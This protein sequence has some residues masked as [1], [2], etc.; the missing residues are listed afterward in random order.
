M[1]TSHAVGDERRRTHLRQLEDLSA[2]LQD[3]LDSLDSSESQRRARIESILSTLE[4]RLYLYE[5]GPTGNGPA[6]IVIAN[7]TGCSSVYASTMP[8][9]SYLD[10][11]VNSL[12]QDSSPLAKGI[13][14]GISAQ[15]V[16]D[17]RAMRLAEL[18]LADAYDPADHELELRMLSWE[19]FTPEELHLLPTVM[20]I[21]GDGATYDIGFGALSRVLA[22]D[23][24]IKALVLNSG[25]Y[26]NTGGQAST[27]SYT[28]QDSDLARFGGAHHG[29]HESRKELGLLASFHPNVFACATSTAMHAHFMAATMQ[30]LDYPA[31][32]VMDVYTPCGSEHGIPE[33]SSNARARLAVESRMHPLF[34]HD[35]RRGSTLHDWFSLDGNPDIDKT[36]TNSTLEYV[37]ESGQ[38]Q[39][40]TTALTPAVFA[41]GEV[42]FS[43]QFS[44]LTP[45]QEETAVPIEEYVEMSAAQ[46]G[47]RIPFIHATDGERRLIKVACSDSIVHLVED[48]RRYWQTL[49]YLSGV[50]EAQLTALHRSDFEE[51]KAKYEQATSAR[52]ASLDDIARAMSDLATSSRAPSGAGMAGGLAGGFGGGGASQ[53]ACPGGRSGRR[54]HDRSG[55][56][57]PGR[58]APV[59]RL[60]HLLPGAPAVLREGH[61]G[62]RRRD[63]A[64]RPDDPRGGRA[65]RGHAGDR[66]AD[67][68]GEG[69]VRRGD[70]PMSTEQPAGADDLHR[71]VEAST[72]LEDSRA[73]VEVLE[74][75]ESVETFTHQMDLLK[76]RLL[77]DPRAFRELFISEGMQA[78]AWE[79][80]Q[81]ELGPEFTRTLW[82]M[83]LREDDAGTVLMRFL[84][85]LPLGKK[86]MFIRAIDA[87]LSDRYPMFDGLSR[88][89]PAGNSIPPYVRGPEDRAHDFGLVNQGY[90]GYMNLGYTARDIDLL[91]WLEAMRDKQCSDKPC[92][93]GI[94]L[95]DCKEPTGGC[96]VQ[97]HI[98]EMIELVGN[99]R[100]RE[101]LQLIE[102]CNPLPDVT[103]RVCPQELQCQGVCV[104]NKLPIAIGQLEWF[105]PQREK[106]VN[107]GGAAA[108]LSGRPDPWRSAT[109]P[110]VAIVGSGPSGL[111]NAYLLASEGFPVTV[112]EAFHALGGVLRYGIPEFRLPNEL[113]DDVV[114]KIRLLGGRFVQ[115]FVVGKTATIQDLQGRRVPPDLRGHGCG[116]AAV[117]ERPRRAPAQRDER[118][119]VPDP[120]EPDAGPARGLRDPAARDQGQ[121]GAGHRRRQHRDGRRP[122]SPAPRWQRHH[123]LPPHPLGDARTR[124]GAAPCPRGGHRPARAVRAVGVPRR[125]Q[126]RLRHRRHAGDHGAR[127]ARRVRA[128]A[129]HLHGPHRDHARRPGDHGPGQRRQPDHQG[130][131][132]PAQHVQVGNDRPGPRRL[133]G[134][135]ARGRLHRRR[136]RARRIDGHRRSRRRPGRGQ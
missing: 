31:A 102:S 80:Q 46:R 54:R 116:T 47:D 41:L 87:H 89:W 38:V 15:T 62:H 52:E 60:R 34:V 70:H 117:H 96:P 84:W 33:A 92:E 105:L 56:P 8:Y 121:G 129:P 98:P 109:K 66:Q 101:A 88:D 30:L 133:A 51:L 93:L 44:R 94:F 48:R 6:P 97:I 37:D 10:P 69:H 29:K 106:L 11:W 103:G 63:P 14:E 99:G 23:T 49:Q 95:S 24:P 61:R 13:F 65:G 1:A 90:L 79:F 110:P 83:L 64:D 26:S 127:R 124:R 131:R 135:H 125:R 115:N 100:F 114:G 122:H 130:L 86:R 136:R 128:P 43:K 71:Y 9:N 17:V 5:G 120:R 108:A 55:P 132:A 68:A 2:R 72:T 20:T 40:L 111:I 107:P 58:R 12:F 78:V 3:K 76:R 25:A 75:S 39:L 85:N 7:A 119:R 21:G 42:R 134:D 35:P 82:S 32:A 74:H 22:S 77:A 91:V 45:E 50:H 113:I 4:T 36:W 67:R 53:R 59:Q 73:Q 81:P 16:P 19:Q 18:E 123:R 118:Q 104:Q 57:R 27:S 112:F 28:G 126:D